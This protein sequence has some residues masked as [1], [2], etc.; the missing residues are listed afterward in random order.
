LIQNPIRKVLSSMQK[1]G[2]ACLLMGG[3]ACILY[4][5]AEFSR[6]LDLA[7]DGAAENL[8]RLQEAL[9][10][11]QAE[12]I[13]VPPFAQ[14]YLEMGLAIH[15][16]SQHVEAA[17]MRID[18]MSQMRGVAPFQLLWHRRTTL[19]QEGEAPINMLSLPDLVQA[20]KK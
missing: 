10:E 8:T 19:A 12:C 4:G 13:A 6:D 16:R 9:A 7:I 14:C 1:N 5:G 2:V 20:K 11:L 18:V 15:F 3:Q 17:D